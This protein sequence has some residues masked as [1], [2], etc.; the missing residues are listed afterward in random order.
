MTFSGEGGRGVGMD[1]GGSLVEK[2]R[3][4]RDL[5]RKRKERGR[6]GRRE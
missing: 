3:R 1:R 4:G 2:G 6:E 5:R